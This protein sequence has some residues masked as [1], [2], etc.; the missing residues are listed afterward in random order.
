ML[1]YVSRWL[2]RGFL[3]LYCRGRVEGR[4]HIP[5]TGGVLIASNHTSHLDPPAI[6]CAS[7]RPVHFLAKAELFRVPLFGSLIRRLHAFPVN[8]ASADRAALRRC[9]ELL[10]G[11]E[12]LVVFPEG[13]RSP[14]GALQQPELGAAL[15]ALRAGVP[16]VP[17]VVLGSDQ[18]L[19]PGSLFIR[20]RQVTVRFGKPFVPD[21]GAA[22]GRARLEAVAT[23]I[24]AAIA[25]LL[26]PE[27]RGAWSSP[28][29]PPA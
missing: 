7:G 19:R 4:E 9:D 24:M 29:A 16:V 8:R 1:Y 14:D 25:D 20:P 18:A 26:P 13:T 28:P 2:V 21:P 11:G 22:Q 17:T 10:K 23:Q 12:V 3:A 27:R 5:A 15:I 6:G